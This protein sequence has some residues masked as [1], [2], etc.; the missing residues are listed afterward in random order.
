[1]QALESAVV[2]QPAM[3]RRL[4]SNTLAQ[5]VTP[6]VR[7]ALGVILIAAL[8][9]YLGVQGLGQYALVFAYVAT[10]NGIFNDWGLATIC[11]REISQ[12]P[13]QRESLLA[14]A[15]ALQSVVA[16]GSYGL[17]LG[18]LLLMQYPTAVNQ[19]IALYGLTLLLTPLDVLALSFQADLR[20]TRLLP[21]SL[22]GVAL[23]FLL[24]MS[25]ILL[26]G[27][28]EALMGAALAALLAQYAWVARLSLTAVRFS[29]W[30]TMTHWRPF[31]R[32]SWPL[33]VTTVFSTG[34]QQAPILALSR[35]SLEAA[36]LFS[37]ATRIPQQL[38][39][40]SFS[41]RNTTFPLLSQ[42]WTADRVQFT[43]RLDRLVRAS[44]LI[45]IPAAILGIGLA[46]PI[47][48]LLFGPVF[49]DAALPFALL[50]ATFGLFF[51]AILIGEALIAAGFQRLNLVIQMAGFPVLVLLLLVLVPAHGATGA[52]W[53][54][55][56]CYA[57]IAGA[58]FAVAR[59]RLGRDAPLGALAPAVGAA[60][61]GG[62][63]LIVSSAYGPVLSAL[64]GATVALAT[65]LCARPSQAGELW[66]LL[67]PARSGS[68]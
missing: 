42:S 67:V 4:V 60:A 54:L 62:G 48:R 17:M 8:S 68:Q 61:L 53:A 39:L 13:D 59:W 28:L 66:S 16:V 18:G 12:R 36:G 46:E 35:F 22:L 5:I 14:S 33:G 20:L 49:A 25:V 58:T 26:G 1:M 41:I 23:N 45:S 40:I 38:Y 7:L 30:P 3:G 27:S 29:S 44:L 55:L 11:V 10:F 57:G 37:V 52:A 2:M 31:L 50:F 51:P 21:P 64:L 15:A 56:S 63:A 6:A 32:E 24:I 9:R 19:A 47:I 65:L 34:M 43:G